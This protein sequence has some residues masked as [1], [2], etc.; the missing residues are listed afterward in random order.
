MRTRIVTCATL[1]GECI[2]YSEI[3]FFAHLVSRKALKVSFIWGD[4]PASQ[5]GGEGVRKPKRFTES[6]FCSI[7]GHTCNKHHLLND[8]ISH[9]A[10]YKHVI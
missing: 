5:T 9:R 7:L 3:N 4:M 8:L 10:R 2:W 1:E 6:L